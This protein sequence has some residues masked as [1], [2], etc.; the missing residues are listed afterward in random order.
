MSKGDTAQHIHC[1]PNDWLIDPFWND[2]IIN[3]SRIALMA[4]DQWSTVSKSYLKQVKEESPL[5]PLLNKFSEPFAWSN[6]VLVED[7][8][9]ILRDGLKE[10]GID[11][12]NYI[13]CKRYLVKKYFNISKLDKDF[14]LFSFIG[15]ITYQKGVDLIWSIAEEFINKHNQKIAFIIGGSPQKGDKHGE[16]VNVICNK[17]KEK[18]PNNFYA[19][20]DVFR[21]DFSVLRA[22]S[23]FCLMPSRFE[24]GGIVQHE[25][26]VAS[27]PA[28][29]YATGGL[30]DTV[31]EFDALTKKGNGFLFDDYSKDGIINALEKAYEAFQDHESYEILRRN[32]FDSVIDVVDV[33]KQ[34]LS[35]FYRVRGKIFIETLQ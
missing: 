34:W 13:K 22:G 31:S 18:F 8:L 11:S 30:K 21:D 35:E 14:C 4:S 7:R 3:P 24:P 17:L 12:V 25:Y 10:W 33:S 32:A 1:L 6:G 20:Y 5:A 9:K 28:V 29:V 26:F 2:T 15:R 27:T 23:D 19:G 16:E